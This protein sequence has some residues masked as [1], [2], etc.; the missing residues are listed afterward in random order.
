MSERVQRDA[1]ARAEAAHERESRAR[2][3]AR[4]N[5]E[6]GDEAS[7][8]RHDQSAELQADAAK[9]AETILKLDQELD[10]DQLGDAS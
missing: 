7:A 6:R 8:R 4:L 10:G 9:D 5:R 3:R 2:E 1:K